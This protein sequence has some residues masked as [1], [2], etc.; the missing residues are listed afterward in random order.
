MAGA[1]AKS[2]MAATDE[3]SICLELAI[4]FPPIVSL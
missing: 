4:V 2:W 3:S 1:T